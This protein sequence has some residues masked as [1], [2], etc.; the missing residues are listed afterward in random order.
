MTLRQ[1]KGQGIDL[2]EF[3][4]VHVE[5]VSSIEFHERH[6]RFYIKFCKTDTLLSYRALVDSGSMAST[7]VDRG[8]V[9]ASTS[10]VCDGDEPVAL[11][12]HYEDAVEVEVAY[13][14][15]MRVTHGADA[16]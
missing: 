15:W 9:E 2:R 5:R 1:K 16:I 14:Q 3:G 13:I 6:Q 12:E 11:F 7:T 10:F 8:T 4:D